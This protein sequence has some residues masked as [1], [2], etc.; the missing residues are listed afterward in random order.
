[1]NKNPNSEFPSH[2]S[3]DR[4]GLRIPTP[5]PTNE[6]AA[7]PAVFTDSEVSVEPVEVDY[8]MVKA[9]FEQNDNVAPPP[10]AFYVHPDD[11]EIIREAVEDGEI[12]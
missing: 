7:V 5:K 3:S 1:M 12:S 6:G 4:S 10:Q 11:Y 9:L 2:D 8:E